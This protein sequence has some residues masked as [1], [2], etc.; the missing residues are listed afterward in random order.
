[1]LFRS[2]VTLPAKLQKGKR[3]L[4]YYYNSE[5]VDD[6]VSFAVNSLVFPLLSK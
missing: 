5:S 3:R 1:V 4:R 2:V 6:K